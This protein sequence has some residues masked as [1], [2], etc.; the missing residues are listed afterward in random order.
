M[1]NLRALLCPAGRTLRTFAGPVDD[2][3]V[4]SAAGAGG[5][6]NWPL[7]KWA[8]GGEDKC[9]FCVA[10]VLLPFRAACSGGARYPIS[11]RARR[12]ALLLLPAQRQGAMWIMSA[13]ARHC[14]LVYLKSR[15]PRA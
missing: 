6:V 10:G 8:G 5:A 4:G 11:A 15:R 7:F 13:C 1:T 9:A 14:A 12:C 2:Y 3:A